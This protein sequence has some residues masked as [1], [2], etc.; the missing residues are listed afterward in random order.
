MRHRFAYLLGLAVVLSAMALAQPAASRAHHDP[1]H[2]YFG[3]DTNAY[4]P[5]TSNGIVGGV[6]NIQCHNARQITLY[7]CL[8]YFIRWDEYWSDLSCY[9]Q[10]AIGDNRAPWLNAFPSAY[11]SWAGLGSYRTYARSQ[12]FE[13]GQWYTTHKWSNDAYNCSGY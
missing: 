3:C 9:Y 5:Y 8:Q 10:E 1:I 12:L 4:T 7:A 2:T 11:C 6:V 13:G